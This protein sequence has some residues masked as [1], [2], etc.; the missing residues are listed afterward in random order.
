MYIQRSTAGL[1]IMSPLPPENDKPYW[2]VDELPEGNGPLY[3][4]EDGELY[5]AELEPAPSIQ[6]RNTGEPNSA[7]VD[8]LLN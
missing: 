3:V 2:E 6:E 5:R 1:A 8:A 4:T 7:L